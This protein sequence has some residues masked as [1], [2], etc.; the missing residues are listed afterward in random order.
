MLQR[1]H[2][3]RLVWSEFFLEDGTEL[4]LDQH[5]PGL[6]LIQQLRDESHRFAITAHRNRRQKEG[7]FLFWKR[8]REWGQKEDVLCCGISAGLLGSA[9]RVSKRLKKLRE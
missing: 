5:D 8:L 1:A 9:A 7:M 6:M 2:P 3:E 4:C